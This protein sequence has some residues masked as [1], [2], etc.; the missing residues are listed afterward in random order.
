MGCRC[1]R[2]I[3]ALEGGVNELIPG[4]PTALCP[5][6]NPRQEAG[7]ES[8]MEDENTLENKQS[9]HG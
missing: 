4:M 2:M 8:N 7:T 9:L 3:L 5:L 6:R 1:T